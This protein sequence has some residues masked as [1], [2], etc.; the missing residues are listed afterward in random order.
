MDVDNPASLEVVEVTKLRRENSDLKA[1]LVK[2][3]EDHRRLEN[4]VHQR[5]RDIDYWRGQSNR[6]GS[7]LGKV[8]A[9]ARDAKQQIDKASQQIDNQRQVL[10]AKDEA[11]GFATAFKQLVD[12]NFAS[13][14]HQA[15]PVRA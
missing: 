2:A 9:D 8:N 4:V 11:V 14:Q 12:A 6:K 5:D 10:K 3:G 1:D 7:I 13:A 15:C